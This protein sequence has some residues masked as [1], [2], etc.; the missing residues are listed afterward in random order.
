MKTSNSTRPPSKPNTQTLVQTTLSSEVTCYNDDF[1][2]D[3][4]ILD[5]STALAAKV[6]LLEEQLAR[7][8]TSPNH[9]ELRSNEAAAVN[10]TLGVARL[11]AMAAADGM[12]YFDPRDPSGCDP[13]RQR[14]VA[15]ARERGR[16][17]NPS[18]FCPSLH[19]TDPNVPIQVIRGGN[20][21]SFDMSNPTMTR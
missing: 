11:H 9:P 2:F 15:S 20:G 3:Q 4:N 14:W 12:I 21:G 7:V 1:S 16:L 6:R 17:V 13:E 19:D 8:D 18:N 5:L 10:A